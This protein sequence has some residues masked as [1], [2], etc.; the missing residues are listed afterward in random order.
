M[1]NK[2]SIMSRFCI[3]IPSKKEV[4]KKKE[5]DKKNLIG[6]SIIWKKFFVKKKPLEWGADRL[7]KNL[8]F[9]V[10][11]RF[12]SMFIEYKSGEHGQNRDKKTPNQEQFQSLE[13]LVKTP[14]FIFE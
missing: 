7:W 2:K 11:E 10:F 14:V 1:K 3:W 8:R 12:F 4:N 9:V 6:P 5:S 13:G